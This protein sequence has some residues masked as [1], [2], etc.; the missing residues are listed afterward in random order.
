MGAASPPA[1]PASPPS[2]AFSS[3]SGDTAAAFCAFLAPSGTCPRP[4]SG[5]SFFQNVSPTSLASLRGFAPANEASPRIEPSPPSWTTSLARL[6]P[7]SPVMIADSASSLAS[8]TRPSSV[9]RLAPVLASA[10]WISRER[11][12]SKP[13]DLSEAITFLRTS[14]SCAPS[15]LGTPIRLPA[16]RAPA[17]A[18]TTSSESRNVKSEAR[19]A[20]PLIEGPP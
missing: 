19:A 8:F 2:P 12:S 16:A 15:N 20:P 6:G 13:C 7:T 3:S 9:S 11:T 18:V 4:T 10:S 1:A 17:G 14:A 5:P